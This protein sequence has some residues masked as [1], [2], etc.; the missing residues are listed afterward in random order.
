VGAVWRQKREANCV[1]SSSSRRRISAR[2]RVV[3][4]TRSDKE[5]TTAKTPAAPA[6]KQ[7]SKMAAMMKNGD[8]RRSRELSRRPARARIT[9]SGTAPNDN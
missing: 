8:W 2:R 4:W 6:A 7:S 5:L 9:V 3:L 1:S